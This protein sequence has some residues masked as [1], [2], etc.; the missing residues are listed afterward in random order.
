MHR[1]PVKRGL[2]KRPED[3]AWSSFR[4]YLTGEEGVVE[5]ESWW[6]G[7]KRERMGFPLQLSWRAPTDSHPIVQPKDD[8]GGAPT[9]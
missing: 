3:W 7:R 4:H 9:L 2:V 1:N 8:K 6:T 5:I